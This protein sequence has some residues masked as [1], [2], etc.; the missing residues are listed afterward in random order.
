VASL[1]FGAVV[2]CAITQQGYVTYLAQ[3]I[4]LPFALLD[5]VGEF[6]RQKL[7]RH[8]CIVNKKRR[9]FTTALKSGLGIG[10][11]ELSFVVTR[12][13]GVRCLE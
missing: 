4:V 12:A 8:I 1:R 7:G 10:G 6:R 5:E 2:Q 13:F 11:S 3:V 9:Y